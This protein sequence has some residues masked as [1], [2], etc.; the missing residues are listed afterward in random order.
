[1]TL[2]H[3][4]VGEKLG[5]PDARGE[6]SVFTNDKGR[7][8][9]DS[10]TAL[11]PQIKEF[12]KRAALLAVCDADFRADMLG[13]FLFN[14]V[15]TSGLPNLLR[16]YD[17]KPKSFASVFNSKDN[18]R[19]AVNRLLEYA[20]NSRQVQRSWLKA[21]VEHAFR[22]VR[23]NYQGR[24]E[25][26]GK[27]RFKSWNKK[28]EVGGKYAANGPEMAGTKKLTLDQRERMRDDAYRKLSEI[29]DRRHAEEKA[30]VTRSQEVDKKINEAEQVI[31]SYRA[32]FPNLSNAQLKASVRT[33]G[34]KERDEFENAA[35]QLSLYKDVR[36]IHEQ[37]DAYHWQDPEKAQAGNC[38]ELAVLVLLH[39]KKKHLPFVGVVALSTRR[40]QL[41]DWKYQGD[42]VFA[43]VGLRLVDQPHGFESLQVPVRL[44]PRQRANMHDAWVI[45]PWINEYCP[46]A[47]YAERFKHKMKEWSRNGKR[48]LVNNPDG[49]GNIWIDPDP[50]TTSWYARTVA[51]LDWE[52]RMYHGYDSRVFESVAKRAVPVPQANAPALPGHVF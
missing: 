26:A 23:D 19:E 33:L 11:E 2:A 25:F 15:C 14:R 6:F 28:Y 5:S 3:L 44:T 22:H 31:N 9:H 4:N 34:Q 7:K 17:Q 10:I 37:G 12:L 46:V 1:M 32:R 52:V 29:R 42:H 50:E 35:K 40:G 43:I 18:Q 49:E 24:G 20:N 47:Q 27:T 13:G 48:I 41:V 36:Q 45:D 51:E 16:S 38:H 39:A 30:R 8:S 21:E